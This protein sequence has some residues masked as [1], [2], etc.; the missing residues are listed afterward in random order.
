[1]TDQFK[2]LPKSRKEARALGVDRF[3]T[4]IPCKHGH[5]APRYVSTPV[6]VVCQVEH[7]RRLGGW[8]ARPS[9]A[10]YL[11]QLRTLIEERGGVLLSDEYGS[12]KT[13]IRARCADGHEFSV[14]PDNLKRGRWC[15]E[16]KR[17]NQ[18][19]RLACKFSSV[20]RLREFAYQRYGGDCL[21]A[22]PSP[23]LSKVTWKCT[24]DE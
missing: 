14:T 24:K 23:M 9:G 12:A 6:C 11:D 21:A 17:Q 3:F 16:C 2:S 20:E 15:R 19:K 10:A 13:K 1:M 4:G 5:L 18:S 7:A 22:A 8:G